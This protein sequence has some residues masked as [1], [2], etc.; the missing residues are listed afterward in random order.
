MESDCGRYVVAFNGEIYNFQSLRRDL[1]SRGAG[2]FRGHS[3]TEVMLRAIELWGLEAAVQRFVGMFAFALWDRRE[4]RLHL[5]RDRI[6]EKPLYYGWVGGAFLFGSELKALRACPGFDVEVDRDALVP[7][8]RFGY[9]PA[10]YSIYKGIHKLIPGTILSVGADRA[11]E[12]PA[13]VPYW[14]A[15]GPSRPAS[16][17]A[18]GHPTSERPIDHS[19]ACCAT[20]SARR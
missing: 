11:G 4:R 12:T 7:Y 3:D 6:G 5:V 19:I 13:P 17:I 8:L 15:G 9:I 16:R 14:S 20:R 10:P 18:S 2:R 1:E